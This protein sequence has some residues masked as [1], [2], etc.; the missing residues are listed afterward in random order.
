MVG[1]VL[2][3]LAGALIG[4]VAVT[5]LWWLL[6]GPFLLGVGALPELSFRAASA[7]LMTVKGAVLTFLLS[8][9]GLIQGAIIGGVRGRL[10]R[11]VMLEVLWS[12][13]AWMIAV[14]EGITGTLL[15]V[16][17]LVPGASVGMLIGLLAGGSG[18]EGQMPD[19]A[20]VGALVGAM[21]SLLAFNLYLLWPGLRGHD[22]AAATRSS[23]RG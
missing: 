21:A 5:L 6:L 4:T 19:A 18:D 16:G 11:D 17:S 10:N 7:F 13:F 12:P 20:V 2:C 3:A 9:L 8:P 22:V 15:L 14:G 1:R 23:A